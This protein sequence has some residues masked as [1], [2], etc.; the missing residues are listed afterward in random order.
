MISC[1]IHFDV[2]ETHNVNLCIFQVVL[3]FPTPEERDRC[4]RCFQRLLLDVEKE[5]DGH[6]SKFSEFGQMQVR[7]NKR[8]SQRALNRQPSTKEEE[9]EAYFTSQT[10]Y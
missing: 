2:G 4:M 6:S 9:L 5:L 1:C 10:E 3:E 8:A 7:A